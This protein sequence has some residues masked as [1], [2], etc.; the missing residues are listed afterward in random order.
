M[1]SMIR[2]GVQTVLSL[3]PKSDLGLDELDLLLTQDRALIETTRFPI[4]TV[5]ATYRESLREYHGL[6]PDPSNEDVVFSRAHYSMAFGAA[7][8]AWTD[9]RYTKN[10]PPKDAVCALS[11]KI[12]VPCRSDIAWLLDPTNYVRPQYWARITRTELL[13]RVIARNPLLKWLKDQVDSIARNNLPITQAITP[14][15]IYTFQKVTKPIIS[16]HYESGNILASQ[17]KKVVQVVTD[18]HV[19]PQYVKHANL[20]NIKF[21]VMDETTKQ[22]LIEMAD[23]E[24][25][26]VD[27]RRVII[28]GPPVDPRIVQCRGNRTGT[29]P[30]VGKHGRPLR[31]AI[32]TGGLRTN[33]N[34]I[35]KIL[36]ELFD[37][38]RKRPAPVQLLCYAGTH[39]D[40]AEMITT[41]ARKER[42]KISPLEDQDAKLRVLHGNHI[43]PLNEMLIEY[44]F[45]WADLII[46]KPSGD[47]AY[48]AAASGSAMLFLQPWGEWEERIQHIFE[49]LGIGRKASPLQITRQ[50]MLLATHNNR[51]ESWIEQAHQ[52]SIQLSPLFLHGCKEILKIAEQWE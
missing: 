50:V 37:L 14:P 36:Y 42:V 20:P 11:S 29:R 45:P 32:T 27:P 5:S 30:L 3:G 47:M 4:V 26:P 21:A 13:G 39:D 49:S 35:V 16:F 8:Q 15:L 25:K 44:M 31:I 46:T 48:E 17:G 33:M 52:K 7:V 43:V 22:D 24:G 51:G 10:L 19:R 18:P 6:F 1:I 28:T 34:E 41:I 9:P 40:F 2:R 12:S 23:L 38:L